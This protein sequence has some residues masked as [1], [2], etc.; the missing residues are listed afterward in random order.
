MSRILFRWVFWWFEAYWIIPFS[1]R[2]RLLCEVGLELRLCSRVMSRGALE[3]GITGAAGVKLVG[4]NSG[5]F[6][7][8][9][10]ESLELGVYF[11]GDFFR[12]GLELCFDNPG[13]A[14]LSISDRY[15]LPL[16][17]CLPA[18]PVLAMVSLS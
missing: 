18:K 12:V 5:D 16:L 15:F 6:F 14:A 8:D 1:R 2:V 7:F 10:D 4:V 13:E 9:F 11:E 3:I 17:L